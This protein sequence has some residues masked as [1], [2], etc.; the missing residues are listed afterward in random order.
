MV[1]VRSM[2]DRAEQETLQEIAVRGHDERLTPKNT[3]YTGGSSESLAKY[4]KIVE[5]NGKVFTRED[6]VVGSVVGKLANDANKA[7]SSAL[8]KAAASESSSGTKSAD[9]VAPKMDEGTASMDAD[10]RKEKSSGPFTTAAREAVMK[11]RPGKGRVPG[12]A[13]EPDEVSAEH[14]S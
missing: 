1:P 10:N 5:K 2:R 3:P 6:T 14:R 11:S 9:N 8:K 7:D 13:A 12:T 4:P